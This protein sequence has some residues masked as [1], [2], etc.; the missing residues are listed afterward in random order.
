MSQADESL[1]KELIKLLQG[2]GAHAT[3][4]EAVAQIPKHN[5][6]HI[7]QIILLRGLLGIWHD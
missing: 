2:G 5:S 1:R 3:F 7:G 4:E 6:Y